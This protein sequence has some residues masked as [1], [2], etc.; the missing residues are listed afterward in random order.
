MV[1]DQRGLA[2]NAN[3]DIG[4]FETQTATV[5][6]TLAG[7]TYNSSPFAVTNAVVS[8]SANQTIAS[9]GNPSLSYDYYAGTLNAAQAASATPLANATMPIW[10]SSTIS[11]P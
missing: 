3:P 8:N 1:T 6:V 5:G 10:P 11:L 4:A 7:G 2:R 9:F